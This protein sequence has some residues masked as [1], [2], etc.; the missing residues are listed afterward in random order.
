[1]DQ[2][3]VIFHQIIGNSFSNNTITSFTS[4][5]A[6]PIEIEP[7]K[8]E[9]GVDDISCPKGYRKLLLY[10]TLPLD[11]TQIKFPV[12]HYESLYDLIVNLAQ[13]F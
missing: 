4:K 5:L 13:F 10:N 12:K 2:F 11:S 1:M 7:C 9:V 6:T 8:R 3:Y